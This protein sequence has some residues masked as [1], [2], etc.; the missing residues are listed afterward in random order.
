[1]RRVLEDKWAIFS[2]GA[3]ADWPEFMDHPAVFSL[4]VFSDDQ[5]NTSRKG[6]PAGA[7]PAIRVVSGSDKSSVSSPEKLRGQ[8]LELVSYDDPELERQHNL[9]VQRVAQTDRRRYTATD[10]SHDRSTNRVR[11]KVVD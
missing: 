10:R 3:F 1:M 8:T 2:F 7:N 9:D 11:T 5:V 4:G 6:A